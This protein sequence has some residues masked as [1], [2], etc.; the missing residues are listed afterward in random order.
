MK[1]DKKWQAVLKAT[2]V[3]SP[4]NAYSLN[5]I[6]NLYLDMKLRFSHLPLVGRVFAM[7]PHFEFWTYLC[8]SV[9]LRYSKCDYFLKI[10]ISHFLHFYLFV[11]VVAWEKLPKEPNWKVYKVL[12][13]TFHLNQISKL[14]LNK[15][16]RHSHLYLVAGVFAAEPIFWVLDIFVLWCSAQTLKMLLLFENQAQSSHFLYFHIFVLVVAWEMLPL[17]PN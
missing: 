5:Q 14:H 10:R 4:T 11:L 1:G 9:V 6:S 2:A 17:Q 15:K 12:S 13:K 7:K 16:L 3:E 8:F